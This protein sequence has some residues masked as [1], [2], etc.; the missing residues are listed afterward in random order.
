MSDDDL[1]K[2]A[3]EA[4]DHAYEKWS[5]FHREAKKDIGYTLGNPWSEKDKS[6]LK[7]QERDALVWN[8]C[9]RM[10]N[11]L[12]GT[13]RSNRLSVKLDPIE[14]ADRK[15]VDQH[16]GTIQFIFNRGHAYHTISDTYEHGPLMC[17]LG[18]I[19]TY[20]DYSYDPITGDVAFARI[21][22]NQFLVDPYFTKP[23]L[24]DCNF[25]RLRDWMTLCQVQT[26]MPSLKK[27]DIEGTIQHGKDNKFPDNPASKD[28]KG[29]NLFKVD[30]FYRRVSEDKTRLVDP[31]TG[32]S[33]DFPGKK[34]DLEAF[35]A[36]PHDKIPDQTW[37]QLV[38][39]VRY[40]KQIVKMG[41]LVEDK[42]F[43]DDFEPHGLE[44]FPFTAF[45]G[46]FTPESDDWR[47]RL[48]GVVRDMR[49]PQTNSNR[50]RMKFIDIMDN[51]IDAVVAKKGALVNPKQAYQRGPMVLWVNDDEGD[52]KYEIGKDVQIMRGGGNVSGLIE[53]IQMAD[54]DIEEIPGGNETLLGLPSKDDPQEAWVMGK[55]RMQA[56]LKIFEPLIDNL[57]AS[58][59]DLAMKA[60]AIV[61][62]N[63]PKYKVGK[64]LNEEPTPLY[65]D[66]DFTHYNVMA[67]PGLLTESQR[68]MKHAQ[69]M[70]LEKMHP[71]TFPIWMILESSDLELAADFIGQLK[72]ADEM[73]KKLGMV[74]IQQQMAEAKASLK[75]IEADTEKAKGLGMKAIMDALKTKAEIQNM[76][77]DQMHKMIE[78]MRE[79]DQTGGFGMEGSSLPAGQ[80]DQQVPTNP[81]TK[82]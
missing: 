64:I 47:N 72:Q 44:E 51:F 79:M 55:L 77:A 74:N 59:C 60:L 21:P 24:T 13:E 8:R 5:L 38:K 52:R 29:K 25:I 49:D 73:K 18:L 2:D 48:C 20:L 67:V 65:Y 69:M 62:N 76:P 37:G 27:E 81:I 32:Q 58:T 66:K 19:E 11:L 3:D 34:K 50:R 1:K 33:W 54:K 23:N 42:T 17:G 30:R 26:M 75:K 36:S 28:F 14:G 70:A 82:R 9:R 4:Y 22:Y 10:V 16:S 61:Q 7:K 71:G 15:T 68:Q 6:K 45:V 31:E 35:L 53:G 63:Y 40:S 78:L 46:Y 56:G 57:R 80:E 39:P 41:L 43:Y 12:S